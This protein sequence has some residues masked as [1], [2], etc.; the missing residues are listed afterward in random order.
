MET[1]VFAPAKVNLAL[2]VT[3]QR[4]DGYHLLDSLVVFARVGDEVRAAQDETLRLHI[5]GSEAA[6]LSAGEDN[7]VLR[8]ARVFSS[9]RGAAIMLAKNLPVASGIGGGSADA[10]ATLQALARL[11][12][13]PL[14]SM[15]AAIALGADVP[16][17][18]NG[19]TPQRMRGIGEQL[20]P[21]RGLPGPLAMVLVNPR[22]AVSTPE[23]FKALS[24]KDNPPLE[25]VN[26]GFGTIAGFVT[27]LKRQRNDL[28]APAIAKV[29]VIGEVLRA[30]SEDGCLIA[31]MSGSGATCFG[32]YDSQ[33]AAL[34]AARRLRQT[35]PGWWIRETVAIT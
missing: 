8:A 31:R 19:P 23:V 32:L 28:E 33:D 25:E 35:Y 20:D 6:G 30:L 2:H 10:A 26:D 12:D 1:R 16:V 27:W 21:F 7:L 3:G 11:W 34:G 29:P 14:P 13:M 5:V 15:D 4:A 9:D 18:L 24:R 22:E 17:C